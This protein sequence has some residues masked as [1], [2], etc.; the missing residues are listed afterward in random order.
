MV[1]R[2]EKTDSPEARGGDF[3][4]F[5]DAKKEDAAKK[6]VEEALKG[7]KDILAD[8][9]MDDGDD[10]E[11]GDG[12]DGGGGNWFG[13]FSDGEFWRRSL[14]DMWQG[15]S[16]WFASTMSTLGAIFLFFAVFVFI[17][18]LGPVL[19]GIIQLLRIMLRLD[20]VEDVLGED[21]QLPA[22]KKRSVLFDDDEEDD[23]DDTETIIEERRRRPRGELQDGREPEVV[24]RR[25]PL[26]TREGKAAAGGATG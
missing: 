13:D 8:M 12:S 14:S 26:K 4:P 5:K 24:E 16:K 1:I 17:S 3:N 15:I 7:K 22:G 10:G 19:R 2:A 6:A 11:G 21:K 25:R 23:D 18:L 9:D 20:N